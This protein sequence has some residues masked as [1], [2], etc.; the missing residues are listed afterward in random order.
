MR[1]WLHS[2]S[3]QLMT[4]IFISLPDTFLST[5][6]EDSLSPPCKTRKISF[7][8]LPA[9]FLDSWRGWWVLSLSH[10]GIC[11]QNHVQAAA[12]K[13]QEQKQLSPRQDRRTDAWQQGKPR[14]PVQLTA[15]PPSPFHSGFSAIRTQCAQPHGYTHRLYSQNVWWCMQ[16]AGARL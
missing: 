5:I 8:E 12:M 1:L 10:R 15:L 2:M 16:V 14:L 9:P 6:V 13:K 11:P 7:L 3:A 4:D